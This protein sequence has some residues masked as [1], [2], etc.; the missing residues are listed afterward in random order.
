METG[1]DRTAFVTPNDVPKEEPPMTVAEA[2]SMVGQTYRLNWPSRSRRRNP[3]WISVVVEDV[4][5]SYG[6]RWDARIRPV[7]DAAGGGNEKV[8]A[9]KLIPVE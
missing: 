3:L 4:Y 6:G 9:A 7:D 1:Q 8:Y 5:P 2:A